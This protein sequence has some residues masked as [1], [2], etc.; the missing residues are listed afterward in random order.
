MTQE[1]ILAEPA[2][3]VTTQG[4]LPRT[5]DGR[6]DTGEPLRF[7]QVWHWAVPVRI[8]LASRWGPADLV[9]AVRARAWIASGRSLTIAANSVYYFLHE[10]MCYQCV[11]AGTARCISV[12]EFTLSDGGAYQIWV[13]VDESAASPPE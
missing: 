4:K 3:V 6:P 12:T 2:T 13:L 5:Q 7:E 9:P 10:G 8:T 1:L 11:L